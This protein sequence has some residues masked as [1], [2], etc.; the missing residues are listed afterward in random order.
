M[1]VFKSTFA[2]GKPKFGKKAGA[3]RQLCTGTQLHDIAVEIPTTALDS[4]DE[5]VLLYKFSDDSDAYLIRD[6]EEQFRV[7]VDIL[8]GVS[9]LVWSMGLSDSD[10][11]LDTTFITGSTTG[12]S[13]GTQLID[14]VGVPLSVSGL[15]LTLD[16]TTAAGTPT[17]GTVQVIFNV[18]YGLK[19]EVDN[20]LSA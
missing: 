15:Y 2:G 1:A 7:V 8:D 19:P 9:D 14:A 4:A 10:G 20:S 13:A 6:E 11:V 18:S 12:Q 3:A 5:Q 17:E 16:V